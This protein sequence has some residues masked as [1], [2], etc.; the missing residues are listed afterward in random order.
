MG[1]TRIKKSDIDI[2]KNNIDIITNNNL[3]EVKVKDD[4]FIDT[5]KEAKE[6]VESPIAETTEVNKVKSLIDQP[7][8]NDNIGFFG[9]IKSLFAINKKHTKETQSSENKLVNEELN[10]NSTEEINS[11]TEHL[12]DKSIVE[13][14]I[15]EQSTE[16]E[17]SIEETKTET[18]KELSN[19]TKNLDEDKKT[20]IN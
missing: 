7:K 12:A 9:K 5:S 16:Q 14:Y 17:A 15:I 10:K 1:R 19:E 20:K 18:K 6:E 3:I 2:S 13:E 8:S 4:I 11:I